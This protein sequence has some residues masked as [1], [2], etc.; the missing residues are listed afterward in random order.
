MAGRDQ[1][2]NDIDVTERLDEDCN[3]KESKTR[4]AASSGESVFHYDG[5]VEENRLHDK[6]INV[7]LRDDPLKEN[8]PQIRERN[9]KAHQ[10]GL[11]KAEVNRLEDI[12]EKPKSVFKIRLESG[13]PAKVSSTNLALENLK[14]LMKI[15]LR[16]Y[17]ADQKKF[18]YI[19]FTNLV[20]IGFLK[21]FAQAS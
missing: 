18:L 15:K 17:P 10:N 9:A 21:L 16:K 12:I 13:V 8:E 6:D 20:D 4:I 1:Y 5:H 14:K 7:D 19:Y 3:E 2:G 11:S